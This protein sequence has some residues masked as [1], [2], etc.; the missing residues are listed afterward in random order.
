MFKLASEPTFRAKLSARVPIDGGSRRETFEATYRV[1]TIEKIAE[2]DL[3]T[4][5]GTTAFIKAALVELH[6]IAD[7]QGNPVEYSDQVRDQV[8]NLPYARSAITQGYFDAVA[9]ARKGN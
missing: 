3:T 4:P 7:E 2:F 6:D 8:I 9:G 5:E 1:L